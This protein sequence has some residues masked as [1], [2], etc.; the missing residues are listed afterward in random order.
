MR[1]EN[2]KWKFYQLLVVIVIVIVNYQLLV[3]SIR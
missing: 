1:I 3:I 2:G